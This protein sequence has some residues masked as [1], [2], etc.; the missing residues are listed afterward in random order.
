VELRGQA[1]ERGHVAEVAV[2]Q[3]VVHRHDRSDLGVAGQGQR[4]GMVQVADDVLGLALGV[5]AVDRQ[6]GDVDLVA[7][8][9]LG[10]AVP[11][12][13]VAGVVEAAVRG[14]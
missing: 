11:A 4:L 7:P 1:G 12:Q 10:L 9:Q 2:H 8:E 3:V 5:A 13:G 6:Q 14:L